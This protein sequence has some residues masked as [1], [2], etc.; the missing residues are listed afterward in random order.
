MKANSDLGLNEKT[1]HFYFLLKNNGNRI[2]S[3]TLR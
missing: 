3:Q 2:H 1:F